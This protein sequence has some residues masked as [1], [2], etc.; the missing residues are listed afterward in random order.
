MKTY[1]PGLIVVVMWF[2]CRAHSITAQLPLHENPLTCYPTISIDLSIPSITIIQHNTPPYRS[3]NGNCFSYRT[4][5]FITNLTTRSS[6][7][8][9]INL[10]TAFRLPK[11]LNNRLRAW[12]IIPQDTTVTRLPLNRG[13]DYGDEDEEDSDYGDL[14]T[15]WRQ[16]VGGERTANMGGWEYGSRRLVS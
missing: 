13:E 15:G 11:S 8:K 4:M 16:R 14:A 6:G 9:K 1:L 3:Q 7:K 5:N 2:V 12:H 10:A